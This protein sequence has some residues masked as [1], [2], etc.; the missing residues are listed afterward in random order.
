MS[1]Q[2]QFIPQEESFHTLPNKEWCLMLSLNQRCIA[3]DWLMAVSWEPAL[4]DLDYT[5]DQEK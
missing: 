3:Q 2:L 4:E 1:P 5:I